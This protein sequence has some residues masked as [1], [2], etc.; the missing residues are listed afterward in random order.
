MIEVID[1]R[2][3]SHEVLEHYRFRAI[4]LHKE[5]R[6]VNDIANFFGIHRGSVSRWITTYNHKGKRA[7]RSR[8]SDGRPCKL[9]QE[10]KQEILSIL[11]E[12]PLNCGFETPL[13]D[14]KRV[15]QVVQKRCNKKIHQTS[16]MRWL[17][18]FNFTYQKP[19]RRSLEQDKK[20]VKRWLSEEWP[21]I[22]AHRRR[23]QAMLYFQ[24]EAGVSLTAAMGKTWAKKGKTPI[25]KVTGNKGTI[26]IT[27][28]I[29]P[30]GR[31][32]FRI[33][34]ERIKAPQH[35]EFLQQIL[36]RHPNRKII[37]VEDRARPHI[38]KEVVSFVKQNKK[39]FALY[40]LPSY[41]PELNPD[42]HVWEYL[43]VHQLKSHQAQTREQ[44]KKI[45]KKK[46]QSIQRKPL[47]IT[48]FFLASNVT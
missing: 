47:L 22:K 29:S 46:M 37:V 19:A 33:E 23:W 18:R 11:K 44:L 26:I 39:R 35:I 38:A 45:V 36:A 9:N 3:Y 32:V 30:A 16:I 14:C 24:D 27:S 42:E 28:A 41:C 21:K 13:W 8:K 20:A 1:G 40:H 12:N 31:M 2:S 25:V 5:G 17:K 48:S 6:K 7:L 34:N 4:E 15:K 43:K 10:D